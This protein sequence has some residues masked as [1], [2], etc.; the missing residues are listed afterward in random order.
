VV[1][2]KRLQSRD[3]AKRSAEAYIAEVIEDIGT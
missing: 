3:A 2:S 1:N